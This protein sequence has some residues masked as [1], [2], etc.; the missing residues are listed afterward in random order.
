MSLSINSPFL[1]VEKRTNIFL[2]SQLGR[3][4]PNVSVVAIVGNGPVTALT[5]TMDRL[6]AKPNGFLHLYAN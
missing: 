2:N 5:A 3:K 4:R 1:E 6:W